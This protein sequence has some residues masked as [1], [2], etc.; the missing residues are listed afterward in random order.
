MLVKRAIVQICLGMGLL[1]LCEGQNL[2]PNPSFEG[3]H[4]CPP[5]PG[6]IHEAQFWD[7]PNNQTSDFFHA[8]ALQE[9]GASVPENLFGFQAAYSGEAYGGIRS[10]IPSGN[11]PVYR[12]YL[13]VKLMRPLRKNRAY[14]VSFWVS[15]AENASHYSDGIGAAFYRDSL[16]AQQIYEETP[17]LTHPRGSLL[18]NVEAWTQIQGTYVAEGGEEFLLIGNFQNDEN[19]LLQPRESSSGEGE[20]VYYYIDQVEVVPCPQLGF[21]FTLG[22]DTLLCARDT[23]VLNPMMVDAD[24]LWQDGSRS[25][26]YTVAA[27]GIYT[28]QMRD[29]LCTLEDSIEI[30]YEPF[31]SFLGRDTTL[32]E[33]DSLQIGPFEGTYIWEGEV[34]EH[35]FQVGEAGSYEVEVFTPRCVYSGYF[36]VHLDSMKALQ[37]LKIDTTICEGIRIELPPNEVDFIY[38]WEDQFP[39]PRRWVEA[40]GIFSL[41]ENRRCNPRKLTYE[42]RSFPETE[43]ECVPV[44]SNFFSPNGDGK[45]DIWELAAS[46]AYR[47]IQ[48][49]IFDRWGNLWFEGDGQHL[50]WAG[51]RKGK[52]AP[53]G[54]YFWTL[55][56]ICENGANVKENGSFLLLP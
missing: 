24:Y 39:T 37:P 31:P 8:C 23:L 13:G 19:T 54:V 16:P 22:M 18:T 6:Q 26:S 36:T 38:N 40:P 9:N 17:A 14:W 4:N 42:V 25:T 11:A 33:G 51:F 53:V 2:V 43:C 20:M 30:A 34:Y 7:S 56:M 41:T 1:V 28:L 55:T 52:K 47:S 29:S 49:S 45:N 3:Y 15:P 5:Y 35:P 50:N 44:V 12:E 32:C 46:S 21:S 48:F 27:A 10:W